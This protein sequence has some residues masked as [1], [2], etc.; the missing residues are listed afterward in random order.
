MKYAYKLFAVFQRLYKIEEFEE[1]GVGL[2]VVQGIIHK[3]GGRSLGR[4]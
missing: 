4:S 1:T 2:T 3:Y